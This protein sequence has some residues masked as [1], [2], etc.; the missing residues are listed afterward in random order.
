M[1]IGIHGKAR[2]G[3]DTIADRLV[4]VHGFTKLSFA[5]PIKRMISTLGIDVDS[6]Q[7]KEAP[8][9]WLGASYRQ[10]A[11]TL[12]TEWGRYLI[13]PE[14]WVLLVKRE[15]EKAPENNYV[16]SDVRFEN[17]AAW[18]RSVGS[19]WVVQRPDL[20]MVRQH[21]SEQGLYITN[22]DR[23]FINDR[24]IE[25]LHMHVD[26]EIGIQCEEAGK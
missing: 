8:I 21:V 18:I 22:K 11:Q 19:L 5:A 25:T 4:D 1:I 16:L 14:M 3:K 2:S 7:D 17:E 24:T 13:H 23:L 12:G 9:E 10:L 26:A 6:I 15:I 20:P